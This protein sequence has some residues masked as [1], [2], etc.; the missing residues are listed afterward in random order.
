MR[1]NRTRARE[2]PPAADFLGR[3]W[4]N[5]RRLWTFLAQPPNKRA[6]SHGFAGRK[7]FFPVTGKN[8]WKTAPGVFIISA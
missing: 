1:A 6:L 2:P 7:D 4:S 8:M 5:R 3:P